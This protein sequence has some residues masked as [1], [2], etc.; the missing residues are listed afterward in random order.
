MFLPLW[1]IFLLAI[2]L[3]GIFAKIP[4][5]SGAGIVLG[6]LSLLAVWWRRQ[7][8]SGVSYHRRLMYRR[9][10]PGEEISLN[11]EVENRKFLPLSWLQVAD[12]IA[13]AIAPKDED[14]VQAS[15]IA[16]TGVL[17]NYFS[18]RWFER[19]RYKYSLLLRKRGVFPIG[20]ARMES[21]D[22]FGLFEARQVDDFNMDYI[23]VFPQPLAIQALMPPSDDPLGERKA[24]RR[25]FEDPNLVMGV[26]DYQP[27]DD[28]RRVHWPYTARTGQLQVKVYQP[29]STRV[30]V[31][32]LNASTMVNYW[33]GM[34]PELLEHILRVTASLLQQGL[35][36]G[37]QVGLVSNG[38]LA[39][40]DRPF[41][42]PPGRSSGQLTHLLTALAGVTM[43]VSGPFDRFLRNEA[44]R[45]PYGAHLVIV[46]GV[47]YP[48]LNETIV[49]LKNRGW[50]IT[51]LCFDQPEPSRIT[52]VNILHLPFVR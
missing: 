14:V 9:G 50:R 12:P 35:A 1:W 36:D 8:L 11:L 24:R 13:M 43:F 4:L 29:V 42:V 37:Y 51:I 2:L 26:R 44:M 18:L 10:F 22:L 32:C 5:L 41:R 21:G 34:V 33:E 38:C 6:F 3:A 49:R 47:M 39:H 30:M 31:V 7:A 52:G 20:P 45:L 16:E 48:A 23:T 19:K 46:T 27:E 17:V 40:S 25:L 28:F 15:H